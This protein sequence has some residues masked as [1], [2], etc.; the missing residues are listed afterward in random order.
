MKFSDLKKVANEVQ[1]ANTEVNSLDNI[2]LNSNDDINN[3]D[4]NKNK[5]IENNNGQN[6][7]ENLEIP[8]PIPNNSNNVISNS[9]SYV[10]SKDF[11]EIIP[12]NES[13][14]ID[15]KSQINSDTNNNEEQGP[16]FLD[17]I[18]N[19]LIK[20]KDQNDNIESQVQGPALLENIKEKINAPKT[21]DSIGSSN[22]LSLLDKIKAKIFDSNSD[23][24]LKSI[25]NKDII[26]EKQQEGPFINMQ[27]KS[28]EGTII[29]N[30]NKDIKKTVKIKKTYGSIFDS[31]LNQALKD[32]KQNER[33][34]ILN[35]K[36]YESN[37]IVEY[38]EDDNY[39]K[40]LESKEIKKPEKPELVSVPDIKPREKETISYKTQIVPQE[41]LENRSSQNRHIPTIVTDKEKDE[42]IQKVIKYGLL[43]D[44]KAYIIDIKDAN[45]ILDNQHT[46]LTF[47][48]E[49]EQYKIIEYLIFKGADLNKRNGKLETP[50]FIA[51]RNNDIKSV[52]ILLKGGANPDTLDI[53]KR[54]PLIYAIENG[55]DNIAI[56]LIDSGADVNATN[57]INEGTLN[58]AIRLGRI[59]VR[60]KIIEVLKK[61]NE[62][63]YSR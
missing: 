63:A 33:K 35:K 23:K 57:G 24:N 43:E 49:N 3:K 9:D 31:E 41:L 51:I 36:N 46:L 40:F 10:E 11:A 61:Q 20:V 50:L 13:K 21:N 42:N 55:F 2:P 30:Q 16:T 5:E 44:L 32:E 52:K 54:T 56:Y 58:M 8:S 19:K 47:A 15:N 37:K 22:N 1:V 39:K 38:N 48:T 34:E 29:S 26:I 18:K 45:T 4:Q 12:E 53:L 28:N 27:K 60:D 62:T 25:K 6:I 7:E 17:T 14:N 59:T